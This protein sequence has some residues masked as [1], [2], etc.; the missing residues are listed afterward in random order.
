MIWTGFPLSHQTNVD[1]ARARPGGQENGHRAKEQEEP[2]SSSTGQRRR[3]VGG[4]ELL[5]HLPSSGL[6]RPV[7][8]LSSLKANTNGAQLI[9][10]TNAM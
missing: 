1:V 7:P 4:V 10:F 9:V 5:A 3:R 8:A 6:S 2:S